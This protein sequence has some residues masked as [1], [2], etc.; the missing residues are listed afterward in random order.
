MRDFLPS[1]C[2][3]LVDTALLYVDKT[4][5][6]W[7]DNLYVRL[8]D[9][10]DEEGMFGQIIGI[11]RSKVEVWMTNLTLQGNGD[12]IQDCSYCGIYI[13]WTAGGYCEGAVTAPRNHLVS[14]HCA[15]FMN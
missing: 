14:L 12:G 9:V 13:W 1:Q 8:K 2:L 15:R 3:L 10:R 4:R 6:L 7:L 5:N 11:G